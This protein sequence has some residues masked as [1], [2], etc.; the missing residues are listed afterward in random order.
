VRR[1]VVLLAFAALASAC[2]SSSNHGAAPSTTAATVT[3]AT[4]GTQPTTT[5]AVP[6]VAEMLSRV[7]L[8]RD[9]KVAPVAR[10]VPET[11]A[12]AFAALEQLFAGPSAQDRAEGLTTAIPRTASPAAITISDGV[13]RVDLPDLSHAALAQVVYTLTQFPSVHGVRAARSLGDTKP[14]TRADFEDVT[15]AILVESPL[16]DEPV[17]SPLR[18]GGTANTFEATF[19]L[20]LRDAAGAKL[21]RRVVTATSGSGER[22]TFSASLPFAGTPAVLVAWEPSAADGRPLHEVRIPVRP[23]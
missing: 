21:A 22:G 4:T 15:P 18:V 19:V 16:P 1:L 11:K 6:P 10:A 9:G 14:F 8:L 17:A 3:T 13:A 20:E 5:E 7:Y 2:G 12:V 23:G